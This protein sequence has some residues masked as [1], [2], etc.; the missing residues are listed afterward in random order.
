MTHAI[1]IKQ[2]TKHYPNFSLGPINL[3]IP[4]GCMVGYI[5][6]NGS[7]KSTTIKAILGLV[8]P[9]SGQIKVLGEEIHPQL[10]NRI[11]VV[12][13]DLHLN[14]E[15]KV[16]EV[17][18]F[19]QKAYDSWN[20]TQF[21][22]YLQQFKLPLDQKIKTLSRGMKMKLSLSIA[23]SHQAELL[24]LD[25]ATSGLD[26]VVRDEIL[27]ILLD[28]LQEPHHAVFISSHIL[29]DL[30]KVA[31][32]IAFLHDGSIYFME[33]KDYLKEQFALCSVDTETLSTIDPKAILGRRTHA[34]G[35]DLLV[36]RDLMPDGI[37]LEKP[38]IEDIMVYTIKGDKDECTAL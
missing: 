27:D 29:S 16:E 6:E 12:F 32:Y 3:T 38:S 15:M 22:S 4:R 24:I 33:E 21:S 34:F 1:E 18:T 10:M 17:G 35:V 7:G 30:E 8:K 5:G 13:D 11:G 2:L 31:D 25:E 26:P 20:Q 28:Y 19:C 9:D 36:K 23:L 14:D 37:P